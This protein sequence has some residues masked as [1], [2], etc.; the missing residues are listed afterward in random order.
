M[1]VKIAFWFASRKRKRRKK[2]REKKESLPELTCDLVTLDWNC[3]FR[4]FLTV[5]P[6]LKKNIIPILSL[7][8]VSMPLKL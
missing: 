4:F 7:V 8:Q 6:P 5:K 3:G 1:C 2:K